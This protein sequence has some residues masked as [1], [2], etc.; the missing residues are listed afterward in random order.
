MPLGHEKKYYAKCV[1]CGKTEWTA[2]PNQTPDSWY[3]TMMS[4]HDMTL[5][6]VMCEKCGGNALNGSDQVRIECL[7]PPLTGAQ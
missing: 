4:W 3:Y 7:K 1:I 5:F 2:G 6:E